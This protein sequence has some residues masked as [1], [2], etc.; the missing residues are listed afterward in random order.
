MT[1]DGA[2]PEFVR[3]ESLSGR[4]ARAPAMQRWFQ[5]RL[6]EVRKHENER[7]GER[8]SPYERAF[9]LRLKRD[10]DTFVALSGSD[11]PLG[12]LL[13]AARKPGTR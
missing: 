1:D 13:W 6:D 12:W 8:R 9:L 5:R 10:L 7:D 4:D 11:G 2:R 3:W